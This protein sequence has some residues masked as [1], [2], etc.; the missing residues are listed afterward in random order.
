MVSPDACPPLH[1]LLCHD[2]INAIV[3][4]H[5]SMLAGILHGWLARR[6]GTLESPSPR[7]AMTV[8]GVAVML[9]GWGVEEG[10]HFKT[11]KRRFFVLRCATA[12]ETSVYGCTHMLVYYKSDKQANSG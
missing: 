4:S 2:G 3:L 8:H 10:G 6:A 5:M 11:W 9:A 12:E 7:A 1:N